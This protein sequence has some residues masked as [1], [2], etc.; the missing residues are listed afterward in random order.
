[1]SESRT[2]RP[3]RLFEEGDRVR[4]HGQGGDGAPNR[5][6]LGLTGTVGRMTDDDPVSVTPVRWDDDPEEMEWYEYHGISTDNLEPI[7]ASPSLIPATESREDRLSRIRGWVKKRNFFHD[8]VTT[9]S[10][11]GSASYE[12]TASDIEWLLDQMPA[13]VVY[14]VETELGDSPDDMSWCRWAGPWEERHIAQDVCDRD[15]TQYPKL[16][17]RVTSAPVQVW[18][19][20]EEEQ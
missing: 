11:G 15:S 8:W 10:T 18:T 1:M 7:D 17:F 14:R 13:D 3:T 2:E 19:P 20:I 9:Y 12:M 4:Y 5:S 16:A 6:L